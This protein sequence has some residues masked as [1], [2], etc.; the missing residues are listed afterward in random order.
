MRFD[1]V[2]YRHVVPRCVGSNLI[3]FLVRM[4]CWIV[5]VGA[6]TDL[7]TEDGDTPLMAA[8]NEVNYN[9]VKTLLDLGADV[10]TGTK[11]FMQ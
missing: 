6:D 7:Q 9:C 11:H 10:N 4:K 8:V 1:L 3:Y 2:N 5:S